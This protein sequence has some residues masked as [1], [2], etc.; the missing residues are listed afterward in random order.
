MPLKE[1]VI[2]HHDQQYLDDVKSLESYV[3]AELNVMS[4]RYTSD[5]AA[6]GI[7]YR[8][9]CDYP[10][11]GRRLRKDINKVKTA[12]PNMSSEQCKSYVLD[13]KIQLNGVELVAGDLIVSRYVEMKQ[14][15]GIFETA[16]DDDVI[17]L[18]DIRRHADLESMA[19]LRSLTSRVNKLRKEAGLKPSDR[20]DIFYEY[21][22]G[23]Q[24][25]VL[26]AVKGNEAYLE[27]AIGGVPMEMAQLGEG[28][29]V[30]QKEVRAKDAEAFDAEERFVLVLADRGVANGHPNA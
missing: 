22:N 15:A 2:F 14:Q 28:R 8:A 9:T 10:T 6:I 27:K 3:A 29:T 5:E 21:D 18:L 16:S 7:Q 11:L 24:D 13:G 17:I 23:E 12:L 26:R 19:L 20:V 25:S 4:V 1:L 30:I